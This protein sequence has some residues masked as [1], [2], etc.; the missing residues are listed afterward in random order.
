MKMN[1]EL[2]NNISIEITEGQAEIQLPPIW[3]M[4]KN[5]LQAVHQAITNEMEK[6]ILASS[7]NQYHPLLNCLFKNMPSKLKNNFMLFD[8]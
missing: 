1:F 8:P 5:L 3:K 2:K 7:D 4:H 6:P